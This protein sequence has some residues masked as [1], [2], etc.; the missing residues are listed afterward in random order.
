M[1]MTD[2]RT[3]VDISVLRAGLAEFMGTGLFVFIGIITV[4][5]TQGMVD[6]SGVAQLVAYAFAFGLAVAL[7]VA[8]FVRVS[9]AHVNPAVTLAAMATGHIEPPKAAVYIIGQLA[10]AVVGSALV[11]LAVPGN[12][13]TLGAT[14]LAEGVSPGMGLVTEIMITFFL[15][16]VIYATAVDQKAPAAHAPL[17]IGLAVVVGNLAGGGLTGPSMNPA[18]SFGPALVA[19]EWDDHWVYWVG[20]IIGAVLAA[21]VYSQLFLEDRDKQ[22]FLVD[23]EDAAEPP[24]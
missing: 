12:G 24:K 6:G 5:N 23:E 20:P 13:G 10:G 9:G 14:G 7:A 1:Q 15:I 18:R 2:W 19:N 17:L 3:A 4:V 16:L 21:V 11:M 22:L 8:A